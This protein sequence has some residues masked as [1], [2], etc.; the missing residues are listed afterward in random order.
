MIHLFLLSVEEMKFS[1]NEMAFKYE[2]NNFQSF[3]IMSLIFKIIW[4]IIG[5]VIR[6]G[7]DIFF[8]SETP[9][10]DRDIIKNP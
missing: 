4:T 9:L 2:T 10:N 6:L 8:F 1:E 7:N 5:Q 3:L